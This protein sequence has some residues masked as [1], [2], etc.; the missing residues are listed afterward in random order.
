MPFLRRM[1]KDKS[2][3]FTR[4]FFATDIHGSDD[5]Y[6]KFLNAS[7]AYRADILVMGGDITGKMVVPIIQR[8]DGTYRCEFLGHSHVLTTLEEVENLERLISRSGCYP[9]RTVQ[10]EMEELRRSSQRV[11]AIT[12]ELMVDRI[13]QWVKLAEERL[14]DTEVKVVI[15]AGND[16][17]PEIDDVLNQ[18]EFVINH[19][20]KVIRLTEDHEMIGLGNANVTPWNCPRDITEEE[21]GRKIDDLTGRV[22]DIEQCIFCIHVP[23][24]DSQI[25]T[26]PELDTSVFPPKVIVER[27]GQPRLHGAG[28]TA[29][30][31]AIERYQPLLG[32]HGHIHESRG[33][34]KIRRTLCVNPGSEY[35][36]GILRGAIVNLTPDGILSYQLTSG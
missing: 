31:Q 34:T 21:L 8:E 18:S 1:A 10:T 17:F 25:D 33:V 24:V 28:S 15:G 30:R 6:R 7:K 29:V 19:H 2:R 12:L 32:L 4:L 16:D 13:R 11:D 9:Y 20:E 5:C 14:G 26:C 35:S 3:D 23:P 22:E 36:E 27:G